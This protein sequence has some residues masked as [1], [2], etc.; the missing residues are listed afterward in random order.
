[1][2]IQRVEILVM[3]IG[4]LSCSASGAHYLKS[5][6][7]N[8]EGFFNPTIEHP[9]PAQPLAPAEGARLRRFFAASLDASATASVSAPIDVAH[10]L[11]VRGPPTPSKNIR[12]SRGVTFRGNS[13][14]LAQ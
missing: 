6:H 13:L 1:M 3:A 14:D 10:W 12:R 9:S 2:S 7:F 8:G 11:E 4:L 5:D